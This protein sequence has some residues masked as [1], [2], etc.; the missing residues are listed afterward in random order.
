MSQEY[1]ATCVLRCLIFEI[2]H[3]CQL[4][5]QTSHDDKVRC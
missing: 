5:W 2:T 1:Y 4:W 3:H